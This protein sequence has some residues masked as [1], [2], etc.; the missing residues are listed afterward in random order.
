MRT[1]LV[2]GASRGLG[3]AL[4]LALSEEGWQVALAARSTDAL[5][6]TAQLIHDNG[7]TAQAFEVDL[8][9][10][11]ACLALIPR[12]VLAMGGL[13]LLV[14]NAAFVDVSAFP[15]MDPLALQRMVAVNLT[16]P[17]LLSRAAL[18]G[19]L[20]RERGHIVNVASLAG[21]IGVGWGEIYC[22]T[23]HGLVGFTRAL[24]LSAKAAGRK[25]SASVVCP[26]FVSEAGMYATFSKEAGAQAPA[27]FGTSTPRAVVEGVLR[28][29]AQDLPQVIVNPTPV[30]P[31]CGLQAM[32]PR[33][34]EVL[35]QWLNTHQVFQ[36]VVASETGQS[37]WG[38]DGPKVV[39]DGKPL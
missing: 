39:G 31:L 1:A 24:R 9:E 17:M 7:G 25:V 19:M 6:Q 20:A 33:A 29:V 10:P 26:G 11:A 21:L 35:T 34:G 37:S 23:K 5:A 12:V 30:R 27:V 13:D 3:R 16:A 38:E 14:N 36:Q 22:A 8:A 2:T 18:P 4:A 28:A 15:D 32:L